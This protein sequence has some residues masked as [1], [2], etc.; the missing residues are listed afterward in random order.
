MAGM[1]SCNYLILKYYFVN[2][3]LW[4]LVDKIFMHLKNKGNFVNQIL[5][6][7]SGFG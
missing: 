3:H 2:Q 6:T 4:N 7:K 5:S 1:K